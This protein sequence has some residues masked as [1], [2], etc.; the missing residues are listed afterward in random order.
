MRGIPR[1][2]KAIDAAPSETVVEQ[3]TQLPQLSETESAA[4]A[5]DTGLFDELTLQK[6]GHLL[7]EC[8]VS[9]DSKKRF[10]D[11]LVISRLH[12]KLQPENLTGIYTEAL[13][14]FSLGRCDEARDVLVNAPTAVWNH[15]QFH[16]NMACIQVALGNNQAGLEHAAAAARLNKNALREM[17]KDP[18]LKPIR[19][20][21]KKATHNLR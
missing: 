2:L 5:A 14:L 11:A 3:P 12:R 7:Q 15:P 21:L 20:P 8:I 17:L 4:N 13:M 18:D 6:I 19:G 16:H 10:N 1:P 9:L